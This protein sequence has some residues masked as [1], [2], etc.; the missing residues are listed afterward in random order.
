MAR[1]NLFKPISNPTGDF[2]MF[3]QFVEDLTKQTTDGISYRVV[4]SK[5]AAMEFNVDSLTSIDEDVNVAIASIFQNHFE[6]AVATVKQRMGDQWTPEV[7]NKLLWNTL[8]QYKLVNKTILNVAE[9]T[10]TNDSYFDELKYIGEIPFYSNRDIDN[11][12]YNEIYCNIPISA[13]RAFYLLENDNGDPESYDNYSVEYIQGWNSNN[14]PTNTSVPVVP[15]FT[16]DERKYD[17]V[18]ISPEGSIEDVSTRIPKDLCTVNYN[19]TPIGVHCIEQDD[20]EFQCNAILVFY[21]IYNNSDQKNPIEIYKNIPLGV[22]WCG[23]YVEDKGFNNI[24]TKYVSNVDSFGQGSSYGLR[25]MT[26]F[27]PVPN[28]QYYYS[29]VS[30][31][32]DVASL[33]TMM[34]KL[35]DIIAKFKENLSERKCLT[36]S[37]KDHLA[38]FKNYRVNVPYIRVVDGVPTWFVNGRDTGR[39]AFKDYQTVIDDILKRISILESQRTGED[40]HVIYELLCELNDINYAADPWDSD[41]YL[42]QDVIE[43]QSNNLI[44]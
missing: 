3:S 14:Y 29:E 31:G 36:Q 22:Y 11:I 28:S 25:I 7:T 20:T 27:T 9:Q 10:S 44:E 42:D 23:P 38:M 34:G 21:N 12:N 40:W 37:V 8:I 43:Q 24:I 41:E 4:P 30:T 16:N 6:N 33:A 5:F 35:G 39:S 17:V 26:R 13:K 1:T 2:F 18:K 15:L 32:E 19:K